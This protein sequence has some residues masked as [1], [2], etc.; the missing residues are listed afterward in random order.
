MKGTFRQVVSLVTAFVMLLCIYIPVSARENDSFYY[1]FVG[2]DAK[3]TGYKGVATAVVIPSTIDGRMVTEIGSNA[4]AGRTSVINVTIPETVKT[5]SQDAFK[6]CSSLVSVTIPS[7]VTAISEYAFSGCIS[8]TELNITSALTTIGHYAFEGCTALR[9]IRIPSTKIGF[10]A[11]KNCTA[12]ETIELLQ[13]VQSLGRQAFDG[14]AW[15]NLQPEGLLTVGTAVYSYTGDDTDV[16]IPSGMRTIADF[17]FYGTDIESVVI[18]DG[19]YYIGNSA[20]ADCESL[21]YVS[22]PDSVITIGL[23]A[24]AYNGSSLADEYTIY[25]YKDSV[26]ESWAKGNGVDIVYIDSCS[27]NYSDWYVT[28]APD[29]VNGGE[30][31]RR[32]IMCNHSEL[33]YVDAVGHAWSG[34]VVISTLSCTTDGV[35][36]RTCTECGA[37]EDDVTITN[38]HTWGEW[39]VIT[40]PGCNSAG[41]SKH[42]CSVCGKVEEIQI[43]PLDHKWTVDETTDS[44]GWVILSMPGC[45]E[46][47]QQARIC[48]VCEHIETRAIEAIG[49]KADEWVVILDPTAVTPGKKQGT[50]LICG[51]DFTE[52]IPSIEQP[53]PDDVNQLILVKGATVYF[54]ASRTFLYGAEPGT[55]V[56]D[57]LL[58]F[59]YPGHILVTNI[60]LEQIDNDMYIGTGCFLVLV[61]YSEETQMNEPVDTVCVI[62]KGDING[63]GKLSAA[64]ARLALQ[65]SAKLTELSVPSLLAGDLDGNGSISAAE[66]RKILRV[67]S[68]IDTFE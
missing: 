59:E 52:S 17:A 54:D 30:E 31:I 46:D 65:A 62:I 64:D 5:I 6:N 22:V 12:L 36:R 60:N 40:E 67:S 23:K 56:A 2:T 4:F 53:I 68:K 13:P 39:V 61:K 3:I 7:A 27:H 25:C 35:Q 55:T 51:E 28:K 49:H 1:E 9:E 20:F 18:P 66:A 24:F 33:R 50:C 19:M 58:Q 48:S 34:W 43:D 41:E 32:C 45:V 38:G 26:A 29:C 42:T 14:T 11:F 15:Y 63:D 10:G 16:V 8:L 37:T 21:T 57:V 44:A 47:G